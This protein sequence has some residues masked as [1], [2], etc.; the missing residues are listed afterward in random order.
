[1]IVIKVNKKS[2][3]SALALPLSVGKTMV[4]VGMEWIESY[5][6]HVITHDTCKGYANVACS[7]SKKMATQYNSIKTSNS[8]KVVKSKNNRW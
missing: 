3:L 4:M 6:S 7:S 2:V 8:L 5:W 1:V